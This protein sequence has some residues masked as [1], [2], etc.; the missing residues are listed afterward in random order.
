MNTYAPI[1]L[2]NMYNNRARV[3]E[4]PAI[5]KRW[6][7]D[8][9][10][11]RESASRRLDVR[12][13]GGSNETL[14][15]FPTPKGAAPVL[16]FVHGGYWRALDKS[17]FSFVAPPF[18]EAGACVVIPNYSLCPGSAKARVTIPD[19]VMQTVAAL[20]WTWRNIALYGGDPKRITVVGHSAGGHLA[21]MMLA[22]DWKVYRRD[23]PAN[24]VKNAMSISGLNDLEPIR[25]TPFLA[26]DLGLTVQDALRASPAFLPR[27][28]RGTLYS[29]VGGDESPEFLRQGRLIQTMWGRTRVPLYEVPPGLNHFTVLDALAKPGHQLHQRALN[30][31]A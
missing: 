5:L 24:L 27:P 29:V 14:D 25:Q 13:G 22:C 15:I 31:M 23:L 11:A 1:W 16:V 6:V 12:Y 8:S 20:A 2:D 17:D 10:A 4:T 18:T 9:A 28:R 19:I 7:D 30:L 3:A 21:A 26:K